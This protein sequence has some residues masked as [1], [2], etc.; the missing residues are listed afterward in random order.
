MW[1]AV[2][3]WIANNFPILFLVLVV[4]CIVAIVT[5]QIASWCNRTQT[6]ETKIQQK[7]DKAELPCDVHSKRFDEHSG[8]VNGLKGDIKEVH[9]AIETIQ[10]DI[11]ELKIYLMIKNPKAAHIFSGKR[12]PRQLNDLGRKVYDEI[13]GEDFLNENLELFISSIDEL[14]PQTAL[15]VETSALS[16]L[17]ENT[18]NPIFNRLKM[19][20]YNSPAV[21]IPT[22]KDGETTEYAIVMSDIC[23]ILSIPLR[24]KY[25]AR[26]NELMTE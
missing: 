14:K 22:G 21:K 25:L 7:P 24:D 6:L 15:D 16:V 3:H 2:W 12:S 11:N 8:I 13:D 18:N 26:H 9:T 5:W 4:C 17:I 10:N 20:V 19:W 23:F 1:S